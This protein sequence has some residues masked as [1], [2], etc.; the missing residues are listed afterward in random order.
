MGIPSVV[1]DALAF[2][3]EHATLR[4]ANSAAERSI[5]ITLVNEPE[6]ALIWTDSGL[7]YGK[8]KIVAPDSI[9]PGDKGR[10]MLESA[11]MA[12]G[13]EGWMN[14]KIGENGPMVKLRYDNPWSGSN[15]YSNWVDPE[16]SPYVVERTG[17]G[18][19]NT[20]IIYNVKEA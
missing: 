2:G 17:G 16:D 9:A 6:S 13:C 7:D 10:W 5:D 18:G 4:P 19:D 20:Q 11:G 12:T 1:A 8:R 14:W 3:M 15:S